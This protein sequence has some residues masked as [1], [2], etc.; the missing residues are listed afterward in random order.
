MN[1][2]WIWLLLSIGV[3]LFL[4]FLSSRKQRDQ[5]D[6][7][8]AGGNMPWPALSLSIVATET[9]TL[10]FIG[11]PAL[12]IS[13]NWGFIQVALGY[14][15][16]RY[17]VAFWL[18]PKYWRGDILSAY[19]YIRERL[20]LAGGKA[21]AGVFL[22][23]RLLADGVR[24]Y[25]TALPVMFFLELSLP[26]T[27]FLIAFLTILYTFWGGLRAV[28]WMDVVQFGFY[29]LAA[30]VTLYFALDALG[31]QDATLISGLYESEKTKIFFPT[32]F[33]GY[34]LIP[35]ILGGLLLTIGSHGTDQIIVQ[36]LLAAGTLA[37]A[38]KALLASAWMVLFQFILFLALGTVLYWLIQSPLS[39][40]TDLNSNEILPRFINTEVPVFWRGLIVAGLLAA[41]M[42]SL[43][44]SLNALAGSS[45]AD[46]NFLSGLRV[47]PLARSRFVSLLWGLLLVLPALAASA[48]GNVLEVGLG[49]AAFA[50]IFLIFAFSIAAL[51]WVRPPRF[52]LAPLAAIASTF[53]LGLGVDLHWL[54]RL[55]IG[56]SIAFIFY[57]IL[58]LN[59]FVSV[60][61]RH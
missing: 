54:W 7:F 28:V 32:I 35:G 61:E 30:G 47:S 17:V 9:S 29:L 20:G 15:L 45:I 49:I 3:A 56:L 55:P 52:W 25:A 2:T 44:S 19:T 11:V 38:R 40:L 1:P 42:S 26:A 14:I 27:V 10:T 60:K 22:L 48:W 41:A 24:L 57:G 34:G 33:N 39:S 13:G 12:A 58:Y 18:L 46:F 5:R 4:A 50:Y 36:R 51:N 53:I 21:A 59:Y 37:K 23:T 8:L 31:L 43:S 6:Y 16:G